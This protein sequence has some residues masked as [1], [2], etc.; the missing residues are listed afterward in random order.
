MTIIKIAD[1]DLLGQQK[2][3]MLFVNIFLLI[4]F[5]VMLMQ[6]VLKPSA[7][8]SD[9]LI[10]TNQSIVFC[11]VEFDFLAKISSRGDDILFKDARA[12]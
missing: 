2:G 7:T 1:C 4:L 8:K 5:G 11:A 3:Q 6:S 9:S 10:Q 12:V